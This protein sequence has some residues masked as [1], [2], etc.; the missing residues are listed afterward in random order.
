MATLYLI[1]DISAHQSL[2]S[3]CLRYINIS[4]PDQ[5]P[6]RVYLI[7]FE[8]FII[9]LIEFIVRKVGVALRDLDIAVAGQFLRQLQI[10][11]SAQYRRDKVMSKGVGGNRA[12]SI[13]P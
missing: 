12:D 11:G 13:F 8:Y 6:N 7:L 1:Y 10:P 4:I 9:P 5:I 3:I 2:A